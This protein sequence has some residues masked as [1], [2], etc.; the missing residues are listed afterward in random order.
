M[1]NSN[2]ELAPSFACEIRRKKQANFAEHRSVLTCI[3]AVATGV[4]NFLNGTHNFMNGGGGG[5]LWLSGRKSQGWGS[6][7]PDR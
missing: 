7:T 5:D 4:I 3:H 1:P 6:L 2:S